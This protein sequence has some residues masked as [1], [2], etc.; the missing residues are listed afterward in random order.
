YFI[1]RQAGSDSAPLDTRE[2]DLWRQDTSTHRLT[3]DGMSKYNSNTNHSAAPVW[4][5]YSGGNHFEI[6]PSSGAFALGVQSNMIGFPMDYTTLRGFGT[7]GAF[8]GIS[9]V[10]NSVVLEY[11]TVHDNS[12]YNMLL[13]EG[14][15]AYVH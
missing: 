12:M 1:A 5:D 9:Y 14:H 7:S 3:L 8:G 11:I 2:H 6:A 10:G 15:E 4:V 13:I